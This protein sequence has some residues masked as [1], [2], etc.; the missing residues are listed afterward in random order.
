CRKEL[1]EKE[2]CTLWLRSWIL[3]FLCW[4]P[5]FLAFYPGAFVY[6]AQEEY[7]QV[8][9]R[10]FT[11]HHPLAHVLLLGG[12][13][14]AGNKFLGSFNAGIALYTICQMIA[15]SGVFGYSVVYI[16]RKMQSKWGEWLPILFYGLFP[17]IPMYAVCSAK[18]GIFTAALLVVILQMLYF[19][20]DPVAWM[21]KRSS[22][23]AGILAAV[24]MMLFRNNGVYAYL[25]WSLCALAFLAACKYTRYTPKLMGRVGRMMLGALVLYLLIGRSTAGILDAA[26]GGKQE[27]LTVPLQQMARVYAYAP[28]TYSVEERD[29]L[30]EILPKEHLALYTPRISDLLKSGFN[31]DNFAADPAKYLALWIKIGLRSPMT[32][33][34]GWLLTSYG[35]W[36][37]DS[38]INVYGGNTVHTYTYE[39]SSFFG[40]ETE[41]PGL[42]ESKLPLLEECYRKLSLTL[43]QQRVPGLSMLFSPGFLF[44]VYAFCMGYL[45]W[46]RGEHPC[47]MTA[48]TAKGG[49]ESLPMQRFVPLLLIFFLWLTVLPGPTYLVRYVLILWFALPV[50]VTAVKV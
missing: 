25:L 45:L 34:N 24:V 8:A 36:Y 16:R 5:V 7:V 32:Y 43:Y 23:I 3:I 21:S 41:P 33:L 9:T 29:T 35:Y 26:P 14:A 22:R 2:A 27:L 19:F 46:R 30:Y 48:M 38:V 10:T 17:V 13:V 31:N 37:P 28:D 4:L 42:R 15:L 12:M 40:F 18:D 11:T 6:D 20:E 44:W 39:E 50:F 47:S 1:T 49:R